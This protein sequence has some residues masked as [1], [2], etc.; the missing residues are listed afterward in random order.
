MLEKQ[1][2]ARWKAAEINRA[3]QTGDK[4]SSGPYEKQTKDELDTTSF[5]ASFKPMNPSFEEKEFTQPTIQ[6]TTQSTTQSEDKELNDFMNELKKE[7]QSEN[8]MDT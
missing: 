8:M 4:I 6:P 5:E 7:I 3:L 2:Y 1:R